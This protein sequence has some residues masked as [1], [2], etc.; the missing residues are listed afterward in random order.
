ML[1]SGIPAPLR[2]T[3]PTATPVH[4]VGLV[5]A[6]NVMIDVVGGGDIPPANADEAAQQSAVQI[7]VFK[8]IFI[9]LFLTAF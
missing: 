7:K 2:L 4:G 8:V 5:G 9:W 1:T 3:E 6:L